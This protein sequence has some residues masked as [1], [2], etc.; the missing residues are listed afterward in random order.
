[1]EPADTGSELIFPSG[2]SFDPAS[3]L[4]GQAS[5]SGAVA[6][7]IKLKIADANSGGVIL[8]GQFQHAAH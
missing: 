3:G 8:D 1:L 5:H 2:R 6:E 4:W 7:N